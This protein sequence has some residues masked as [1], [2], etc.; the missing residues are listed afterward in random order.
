MIKIHRANSPINLVVL[1]I[2]PPVETYDF[3]ELIDY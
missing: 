2:I 3:Q 1:V